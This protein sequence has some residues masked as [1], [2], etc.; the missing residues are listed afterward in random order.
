MTLYLYTN[1]DHLEKT[2]GIDFSTFADSW[3]PADSYI[4]STTDVSMV[5]A[6]GDLINDYCQTTF[7]NYPD[8]DTTIT[9]VCE[10]IVLRMIRRRNMI[11]QNLSHDSYS[12]P[13]VSFSDPLSSFVVELTDEEKLKLQRFQSNIDLVIN[14]D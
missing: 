6:A 5:S 7:D 12:D 3:A 11:I 1:L 9:T 4:Y 2:T 10:S 14:S 13:F 8:C